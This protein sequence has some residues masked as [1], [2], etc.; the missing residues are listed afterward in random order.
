MD[1]NLLYLKSLYE[2]DKGN[3]SDMLKAIEYCGQ[4]IAQDPSFALAYGNRAN[5]YISVAGE[6]QPGNEAF[7]KAEKDLQRGL[8]LDPKSS[9]VHIWRGWLAFQYEWRWEDAESY[10][11]RGIEL[12]GSSPAHSS[13]AR[14]LASLGRFE[15]AISEMEKAYELDPASAWSKEHFGIVYYMARRY[16]E[17][18]EMYD[19]LLK[20]S[21]RFAKGYLGL[22][23]VA[24]AE[25]RD[26]D[27]KAEADM[28]AAIDGSAFF[29]VQRA[30]VHAT[31]GS[32][33]RAN[34]ILSNFLAGRYEG[35]AAP[36]L[37]AGVYY[38]LGD[39]DKGYEW[40]KKEVAERDPTLP[41][42]NTWPIMDDAKKDPRFVE[43]LRELG[44]P[45]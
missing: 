22:A 30:M 29:Q 28:A 45:A 2:I 8:E 31:V 11:K 17:A 5:C 33:E 42:T 3:P 40:T 32:R 23:L 7:P 13:Y 19:K 15:E 35:Y 41:W 27:A 9:M 37:V 34:E 18:R 1:A 24:A 16:G 38:S 36:G 43:I 14:V 12:G 20:Q 44:L 4:A 6:I 10:I 21:P 26:D 39:R 25:R